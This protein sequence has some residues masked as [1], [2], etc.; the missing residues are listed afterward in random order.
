MDEHDITGA[1]ALVRFLSKRGIQWLTTGTPHTSWAETFRIIGD[2]FSIYQGADAVDGAFLKK[3]APG[4]TLDGEIRS[5]HILLAPPSSNQHIV[6]LLGIRWALADAFSHMTLY[7][8]TFGQSQ[9][10]GIKA[11][12]RGYR[13]ELPHDQGDHRYTH[14]Q[15]V[16]AVGWTARTPI[17]FEDQSV[18]DSFPAFPLRGHNL[19][20]LCAALAVALHGIGVLTDVV[21]QLN[22]N[23]FQG[24]VKQLFV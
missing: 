6:C 9:T 24:A 17:P 15:P 14:V 21:D 2:N 11:W 7:L 22:G 5:P 19:T 3:G 16:T 12:H 4:E 23:R 10:R 1:K 8:H 20:T 18:P 13:L